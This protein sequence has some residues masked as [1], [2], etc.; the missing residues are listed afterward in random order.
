MGALALCALFLFSVTTL[1]VSFTIEK[2]LNWN[3]RFRKFQTSIEK[4]QNIGWCCRYGGSIGHH[5]L[6]MTDIIDADFSNNKKKDSKERGKEWPETEMRKSLADLSLDSNPEWKQIPVE[7]IAMKS[8]ASARRSIR[9]KLAFT[10][11]MDGENY[12]IGVPFDTAVAVIPS[13]DFSS[14]QPLDPDDDENHGVLEAAASALSEG[15]EKAFQLKKTP[16][17]LTVEGDLE[18]VTGA[19]VTDPKP[20]P[21]ENLMKSDDEN[22]A[23]LDEFFKS[24]L[25]PNYMEEYLKHENE[26]DEEFFESMK[27]YFDLEQ[28]VLPED[29]DEAK[30]E[31]MLEGVLDGSEELDME[32]L[33]KLT[34]VSADNEMRVFPI[35]KFLGPDQNSYYLVQM[36]NPPALVAK[37]HPDVDKTQRLLI[38]PEEAERILPKLEKEFKEKFALAGLNLSP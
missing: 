4:N 24:E 11:D 34:D 5:R 27:K 30:L 6:F 9:C 13:D 20:I 7:F 3:N 16:R 25:G 29:S 35:L 2:S 32:E 12:A 8:R 15:F 26:E 19:F 1:C 37:E 23:F 36:S 31:T 14:F 21:I 17:I 28:S 22:E 10:V 33:K 38:M 18:S